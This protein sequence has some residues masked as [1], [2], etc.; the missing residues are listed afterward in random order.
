MGL[1]VIVGVWGEGEC[2][3]CSFEVR[4]IIVLCVIRGLI[5][6]QVVNDITIP[7]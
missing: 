3:Y 2:G 4:P 5:D 7:K 6:K 1:I